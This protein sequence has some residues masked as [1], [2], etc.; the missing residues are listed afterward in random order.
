MM[1]FL[2]LQGLHLT[3][4]SPLGTPDSSSMMGNDHKKKLLDDPVV[5][6]VAKKYKKNAG[7]VIPLS[8]LFSA[9]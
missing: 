7:Q 5:N 1:M 6:E 8:H 2:Q 4:Y 3:A 9:S